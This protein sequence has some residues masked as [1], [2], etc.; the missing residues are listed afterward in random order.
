MH[1]VESGLTR[2]GL[3]AHLREHHV[4]KIQG[5]GLSSTTKAVLVIMH[6]NMNCAA[7]PGPTST[8]E[9]LGSDR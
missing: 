6:R 4:N 1:S 2:A 5:I 9:S 3:L 7:N 8:G